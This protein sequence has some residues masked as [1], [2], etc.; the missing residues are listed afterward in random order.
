[1]FCRGYAKNDEAF[2]SKESWIGLLDS[3]IVSSAI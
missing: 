3:N 1:M 2:S